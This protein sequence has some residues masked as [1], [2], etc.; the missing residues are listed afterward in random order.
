M[1]INTAV[2]AQLRAARAI[3]RLTMDE[4]V[5]RT[6]ISKSTLV[7]Y[8]NASREIPVTAM[9]VLAE[10]YGVS[11]RKIMSDAVSMTE[12]SQADVTLAAYDDDELLAELDGHEEMP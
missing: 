1:D 8:E 3:A 10:A 5:A 7:R 11:P 2:A 6:P 12:V 9:A 4:V